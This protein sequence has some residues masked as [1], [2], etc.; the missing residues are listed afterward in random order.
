MKE[1]DRRDFMRTVL[2]GGAAFSLASAIW[3][4]PLMAKAK[5]GADIGQCKSVKVLS[6]SEVGWW[7]NMPLIQ[8]IMGAGGIKKC[9]QWETAWNHANGAGSATLIEVEGLD[10]SVKRILLDTGWNPAYMKWRF[11]QTGVDQLLKDDMIEYLIISHEHVDH[12][13]GLEATLVYNPGITMMVPSTFRPQAGQF[14]KGAELKGGKNPIKHEGKVMSM[15]PGGVHK[16]FK[17]AGLVVFDMPIPLKVKG[18]QSL[19]FN[20]KDKGL[21]LVTGC[22]H[23]NVI[24]F[25]DYVRDNFKDGS[26]LYGLYGGLHMAPMGKLGKAQEGWIRGMGQYGFKKLACNHCTGLPAVKLMKD[27]GYPVV[28][29]RGTEGSKSSLYVGNGDA[30]SFG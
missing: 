20:V 11:E 9:D 6:V 18:E 26:N 16:L 28:G 29:G 10:G 7:E 21:V 13:F 14:M 27:L 22:C 19:V 3:P 30:V 15:R 4:T 2:V 1:M 17:G 24:N 8:D 5:A 25:S 23:Q 12:F